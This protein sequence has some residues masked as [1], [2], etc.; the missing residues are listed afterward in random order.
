[1]S[2]IFEKPNVSNDWKCVICRQNTEKPVILVPVPGT[3]DGGIVEAQ[4]I[5]QT[6]AMIVAKAVLEATDEH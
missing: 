1:M 4:Q 3:E 5:H 6:C 2:R